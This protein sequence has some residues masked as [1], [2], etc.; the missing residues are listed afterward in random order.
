MGALRHFSQ[1]IVARAHS[2]AALTLR[3]TDPDPTRLE[4]TARQGQ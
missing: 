4:C 2:C 1:P 3:M